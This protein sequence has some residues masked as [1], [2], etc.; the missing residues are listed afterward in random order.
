MFYRRRGKKSSVGQSELPS[1]SQLH[2]TIR[3]ILC[4]NAAQ[5][6][7]VVAVN[8]AR[9]CAAY[10]VVTIQRCTAHVLSLSIRRSQNVRRALLDRVTE[11]VVGRLECP[12][13]VEIERAQ[14][15]RAIGWPGATA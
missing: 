4:P 8:P 14:G 3:V 13:E 10:S 1:T 2:D 11:V 5:P 9:C 6:G 12:S 15:P 7:Q